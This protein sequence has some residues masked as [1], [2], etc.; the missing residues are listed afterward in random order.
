MPFFDAQKKHGR[1]FRAVL[2]H[3]N[4]KI[5]FRKSV[6]A[7]QD[8]VKA[9]GT[10]LGPGRDDAKNKRR[11][12]SLPQRDAFFA[13]YDPATWMTQAPESIAFDP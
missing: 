3:Q 10:W 4:P 9:W 8:F 11:I 6:E 7:W 1:K 2:S 5:R 12:I 13:I